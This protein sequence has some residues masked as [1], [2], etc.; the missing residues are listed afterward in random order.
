M[1][2]ALAVLAQPARISFIKARFLRYHT[3]S[4]F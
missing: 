1:I 3:G 4:V 2:R